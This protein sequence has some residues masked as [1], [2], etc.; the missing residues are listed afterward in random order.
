MSRGIIEG[1]LDHAV[2]ARAMRIEQVVG[3]VVGDQFH[4]EVGAAGDFAGLPLQSRQQSEIVEH[5]GAQQQGHVANHRNALFCHAADRGQ[6]VALGFAVGCRRLQSPELHQHGG[7]RLTNLVVQFPR[8]V[9]SFLFLRRNQK[10]GEFS[11]LAAGIF[12]FL[13]ACFRLSFQSA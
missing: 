13:I 5:G 8:Q 4:P 10:V 12:H 2:D 7:H 6:P 9:T 1:F 11:K 3:D